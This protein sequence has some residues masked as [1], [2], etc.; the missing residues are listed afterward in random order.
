MKEAGRDKNDANNCAPANGGQGNK[1]KS[2]GESRS[3]T[4]AS[5][6]I[7]EISDEDYRSFSLPCCAMEEGEEGGRLKEPSRQYLF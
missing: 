4:A 2:S 1:I 3:C 5:R 6:R 7:I